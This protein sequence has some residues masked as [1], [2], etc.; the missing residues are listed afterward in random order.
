M[1]GMLGPKPVQ[2]FGAA[3]S[4]SSLNYL[5]EETC[6]GT[7]RQPLLRPHGVRVDCRLAI[8][9]ELENRI[10]LAQAVAAV[11]VRSSGKRSTISPARAK[12]ESFT[13]TALCTFSDRVCGM[14][15]PMS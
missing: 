15:V 6:H 11:L 14:T 13:E 8:F 4:T 3:P 12:R 10:D 7:L 5:L 1:R 2:L 9:V